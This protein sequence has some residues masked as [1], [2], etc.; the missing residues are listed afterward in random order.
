[1]TVVVRYQG[2]TLISSTHVARMATKGSGYRICV[3]KRAG[4]RQC[5]PSLNGRPSAYPG[6]N[7]PAPFTQSA[8]CCIRAD[9]GALRRFLSVARLRFNL[10]RLI[11]LP[12]SRFSGLS[13]ALKTLQKSSRCL[14]Y[15]LQE[16]FLSAHVLGLAA[17]VYGQHTD[18]SEMK[19]PT[20]ALKDSTK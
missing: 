14:A 2:T 9:T 6:K 18:R 12:G 5:L 17:G 3:G 10:S 15:R 13:R 19:C 11:R 4:D 16:F 8:C 1:M 7:L 20:K